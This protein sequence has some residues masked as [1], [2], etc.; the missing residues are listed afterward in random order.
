MSARL[1][2][3]RHCQT[4]SNKQHLFQGRIDTD[5]NEEG[6]RQLDL[7]A[8]RFRDIPLDAVYSSP[9]LRARRTAEAVARYRSLPVRQDPRLIEIDVGAWEGRS[10]DRL[11]LED[12]ERCRLW[13]EEPGLFQAEG[14][15]TM[16]AVYARMGEALLDI[17]AAHPGERVAVVSH[18]CAIRNALCFARGW[19]I[20]RLNEVPWCDNTGVS[21]L[22]I[23]GKRIRVIAE[24]D[25]S[26]LPTPTS[27][28]GG[29]WGNR[30]E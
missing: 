8:E 1:Y 6:A 9:L 4:G 14:G 19:P 23:E 15:E 21:T 17:A 28:T 24:N 29:W 12:P 2:L 3:I 10:W 30:K 22:E 7:L 18:G 13:L 16:E 26:H 27:L 20:T 5:I 25:R 11:L